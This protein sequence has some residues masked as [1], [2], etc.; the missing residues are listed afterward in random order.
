MKMTHIYV[1]KK[2]KMTLLSRKMGPLAMADTPGFEI[3]T[4]NP[5]MKPFSVLY[6]KIFICHELF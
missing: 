1:Y 5:G 3:Q 2:C 6:N 4:I